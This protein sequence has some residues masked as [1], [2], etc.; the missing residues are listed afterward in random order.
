M[1]VAFTVDD[2]VT[3]L[4]LSPGDVFPQVGDVLELQGQSKRVNKAQYVVVDPQSGVDIVATI[5][6]VAVSDTVVALDNPQK[7]AEILRANKSVRVTFTKKDNSVRVMVAS[8]HKDIIDPLF[9]DKA[10]DDL[11]KIRSTTAAKLE[12]GLIN[13]FDL[14]AKDW[15]SFK[16]DSIISVEY[17]NQDGTVTHITK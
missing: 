11:E 6:G 2:Q 14:E 16:F 1:K 3:V 4:E 13:V 12:Q 8:L 7:M 10:E 15:R 5:T 17:P 9:K